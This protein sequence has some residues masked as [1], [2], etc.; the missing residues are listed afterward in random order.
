[1]WPMPLAKVWT[2]PQLIF[3]S[4]TWFCGI[5]LYHF[6]TNV[7]HIL[8]PN[9]TK[10]FPLNPTHQDLSNNTNDTFQFLQKFQLRFNLIFTEKYSI[11]KNFCI[12]SPNII[13]PTPCTPPCWELSKDTKSMILKHPGL[14]DL[15]T[16][17]QTTFLHIWK[18]NNKNRLR[19]REKNLTSKFETKWWVWDVYIHN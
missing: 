18:S 10:Y 11:F 2:C 14:V 5:S 3:P 4:K 12:A 19:R 16:I 13:E 1:V 17:K 7:S 15:I 6:K 8:N 9:L